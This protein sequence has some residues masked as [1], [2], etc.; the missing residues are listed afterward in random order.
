MTESTGQLF[1]LSGPSGVGK[2]SLRERVRKR[3]PELEYSISYTTRTPRDGEIEGQDYHFVSRDTFDSMLE[4][5]G[6]VEWAEVHGNLYGTAREPLEN[7]L[8][9]RRDVLVEIDVQGARQVKGRFPKAFFVFVLPPSKEA[10]ARRLEK[11]GTEPGEDVKTRLE[12][13]SR[14]LL[15]AA[16]YDYLIVNDLLEEAAE[17]LSAIILSARCRRQVILPKIMS[18]LQ[19]LQQ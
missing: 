5:N 16:W 10:L 15:E 12:N 17:A 11:R 1:V 9:D 6:F 2:S 4:L 19:P 13:A 3:F 18:L 7:H 8:S 14:E